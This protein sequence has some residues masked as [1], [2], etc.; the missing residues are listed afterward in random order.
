MRTRRGGGSGVSSSRSSSV[1]SSPTPFGLLGRKSRSSR[2]GSDLPLPH[3]ERN[4]HDLMN[5]LSQTSNPKLPS[6][7]FSS[8]PMV[9]PSASSPSSTILESPVSLTKR[10]VVLVLVKL[11]AEQVTVPTTRG[12]KGKASEDDVARARAEVASVRREGMKGEGGSE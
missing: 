10:P 2:R 3:H 8:C 6:S 4:T 12:C 9:T 5:A 1:L 11:K 7:P